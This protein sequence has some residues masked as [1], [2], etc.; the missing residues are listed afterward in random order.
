MPPSE[1]P[2]NV[3][4]SGGAFNE[5][6]GTFNIH[7]HQVTVTE[8]LPGHYQFAY[9]SG[10]Q[11]TD[12]KATIAK[13]ERWLSPPDSTK[14]YQEA[15]QTRQKGTCSWFLDGESFTE[16]LARPDVLLW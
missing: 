5:I 10:F 12:R 4:M 11:A 13:I 2:Q 3:Y 16:W 14:N 8:E 15:L 6:S 9:I 1:S 7:N